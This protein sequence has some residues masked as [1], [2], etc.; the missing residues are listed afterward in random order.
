MDTKK[1]KN[2]PFYKR[3]IEG[4]VELQKMGPKEVHIFNIY[5][6]YGHYQVAIGPEYT[7]EEA[8]RLNV[9]LHTRPV[10]INGEIHHLFISK[11]GVSP[12]P[13]KKQVDSNLKN[14]IILKDLS[15]HIKD[16]KGDGSSIEINKLNFDGVHAKENINLAGRDG[17]RLMHKM[18]DSGS[19]NK[20]TY[21]IVQDDI[22]NFIE[23]KK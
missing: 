20:T 8:K 6:N 5:A 12:L 22:L 11:D 13:S 21:K 2:K 17:E 23:A 3:L 4:N 9:P 15:I 19:L 10:E 18:E 14:T 7:P 1:Y 16:K